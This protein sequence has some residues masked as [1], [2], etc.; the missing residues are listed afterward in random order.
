MKQVKGKLQVE[1]GENS[2]LRGVASWEW[3]ETWELDEKGLKK[4]AR[5]VWEQFK[6][7]S[8]TRVFR[9]K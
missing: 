8:A 3:Q 2:G 4:H 5:Q 6:R 1:I 7:L 9:V